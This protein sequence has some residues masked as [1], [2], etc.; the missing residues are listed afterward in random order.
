MNVFY[1]DNVN[2]TINLTIDY[3]KVLIQDIKD[4]DFNSRFNPEHKQWII[5][6]NDYS[7]LKIKQLLV[8][9]GFSKVTRASERE[10]RGE[11]SISDKRLAYV[12][13]LCASKDFAYS[14]RDYQYDC[15]SFCLDK[16]NVLIGD[17]VGLGKTFESILYTEVTNS[18][19]CIVVVPSSVK[20]NWKKKWLE[21]TKGRRDIAVIESKETKKHKNNWSAD[22]VIINYDILSKMINEIMS[23]DWRMQIYDEGHFLKEAKSTRSKMARKMTK[24]SKAITQLLTGTAMTSR[25]E[26]LWNLFEVLKVSHMISSNWKKFIY[27]YC[28]AYHSNFGLVTDGATNTME[29]NRKM[30]EGFYIRREKEDCLPNLEKPIIE[31]VYVPITNITA[32]RKAINNLI[33]YIR[34][35]VDSDAAD[36]A[37][38][39]EH[40]VA[41]GVLRKLSIAG[42]KKAIISYLND[43]IKIHPNKKLLIF[44]VHREVLGELAEKYNSPIINGGVSSEKKQNIVDE[45]QKSKDLFLFANISAGG[46]GVDGLQLVCSDMIIIELP[47]NISDLEQVIGRISRS[48]QEKKPHI[49]YVLSDDT[50]DIDMWDML[51]DKQR[52]AESVNKGKDVVKQKSGLRDVMNRI[53]KREEL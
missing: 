24:T 16:G 10:V 43:W 46:T 20:Y 1:L 17:D 52:V 49:R 36:R 4:C 15:L 21:I 53:F 9:H 12:Q 25:P 40:L 42:K 32:I 45:W 8:E 39:A 44:G 18:F 41:I 35:T 30:R 5:P 51:A 48:G 33:E 29:L 37:A 31:T 50:I 2:K 19:P 13:G 26:E 27:R 6:I 34:E 23:T 28:G 38:E 3:N 47:W 14:P 11:Y 22:V 7:K